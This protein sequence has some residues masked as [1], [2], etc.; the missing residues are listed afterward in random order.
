[1]SASPADDIETSVYRKNALLVVL[2]HLVFNAINANDGEMQN[3]TCMHTSS[4]YLDGIVTLYF[5]FLS[6]LD[7]LR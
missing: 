3:L 2:R 5:L 7:I 1:M 6:F 4:K